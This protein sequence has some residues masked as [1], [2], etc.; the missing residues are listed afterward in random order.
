MLHR[1]G[2]WVLAALVLSP[3]LA[4]PAPRKYLAATSVY[5]HA[6]QVD[7]SALP[8]PPG[9]GTLGAEAD[10]EAIL[11]L[12][13]WR[14]ED[15]VQWARRV[16]QFDAFDAQ[17]AMGPWFTR[18]NLPG[19]ARLLEA[20]L[21]DGEGV[22][23]VAKLKFKRLRPPFQDPRVQPCVPVQKASTFSPP[24]GYYSYPSGHATSIYLLA[25]LLGELAPSRAEAAQ[26]WAHKA[27]WSRMIA[28]VHFPSDDVGGRRLA[29]IILR[30]LKANPAFRA[31]LEK[32]RAEV[33]AK[34]K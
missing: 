27:A 11:Q 16:D 15:Q 9:P 18:K 4:Q 26:A 3:V 8:G 30:T 17:D 21:G 6:D 19:C 33:S 7:L 2:P 22:N 28:G 29:E 34:M 24:A 31:A 5:L 32:G 20:A 25:G 10:L 23:H 13:A 12:Q 1:L 14:T